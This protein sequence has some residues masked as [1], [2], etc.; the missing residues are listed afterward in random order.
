MIKTSI[1]YSVYCSSTVYVRGPNGNEFKL[2]IAEKKFEDAEQRCMKDGGKLAKL[3]TNSLNEFAKNHSGTTRFWLGGTDEEVE[4][5]WKWANGSKI[6]MT[7]NWAPNKPNVGRKANCL[8]MKEGLW[9][10][11]PC[12]HVRG[13]LCERKV[14]KSCIVL[15]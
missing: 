15:P 5:D 9:N 3:D 14:K 4:G 12:T 6:D 10:D 2:F 13:Y 11:A 7:Q 8:T 1:K